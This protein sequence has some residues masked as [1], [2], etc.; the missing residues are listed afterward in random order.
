MKMP[1][2]CVIPRPAYSLSLYAILVIHETN[3]SSLLGAGYIELAF[4]M[5]TAT[6]NRTKAHALMPTEK[7]A[8]ETPDRVTSCLG[9]PLFYYVISY[10]QLALSHKQEVAWK[11]SAQ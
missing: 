3:T 5:G 2:F 4:G 9:L 1:I 11:A 7:N 6:A 10:A 8:S